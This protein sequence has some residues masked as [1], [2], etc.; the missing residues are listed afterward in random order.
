MNASH[1]ETFR[2]LNEHRSVID[3]DSAFWR[4]LGKI[5]SEPENIDVRLSHPDE[6]GRDECVHELVQA[7]GPDAMGID[8]ARLITNDH[9]LQAVL[10][11]ESGKKA[12]HLWIRLR[13]SKHEVAKLIPGEWPLLKEHNPSQVFFER[14]LVLF[15]GLEDE[16]MTLIHLCPIQLEVFRRSFA[17]KVIPTVGEQYATNIYKQRC[18]WKCLLHFFRDQRS[19]L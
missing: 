2:D 1:P 10:R 13:L 15:V 8:L 6:T 4:G 18:D 12:K 7:E 5:K 19:I 17:R 11:L 9:N 3:E 16:T 14:E